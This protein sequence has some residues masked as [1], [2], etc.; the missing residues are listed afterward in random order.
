MTYWGRGQVENVHNLT[1]I[2]NRSRQR[3]FF[4]VHMAFTTKLL[5]TW[6]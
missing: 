6:K 2:T 5:E 4:H 3:H 1:T